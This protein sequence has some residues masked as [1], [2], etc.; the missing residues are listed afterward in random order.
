MIA[1]PVCDRCPARASVGVLLPSGAP[2]LFC[3]HHAATHR[4]ALHRL[5]AE[6]FVMEDS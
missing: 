1:P 6:I 5:G 3:Q 2:L 4:A